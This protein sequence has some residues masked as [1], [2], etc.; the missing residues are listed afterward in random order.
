[1]IAEPKTIRIF[2]C[3]PRAKGNSDTIVHHFVQG[4]LSVGGLA[5]ITYLRD[6]NILPCSGC[7]SCA[8]SPDNSCILSHKDDAEILFK[9]IEQA[10]LVV[11]AS[12]I[13]FYALPANFKAFIDRAQRF[14]LRNEYKLNMTN[15]NLPIIYKPAIIALI[16]AR[17]SGLKLFE[18][19]LLTLKYFLKAFNIYISDTCQLLGFDKKHD[20]ANDTVTCGK[21]F[22]LGI[23]SQIMLAQNSFKKD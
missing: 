2:A 19:S 10:S 7:H 15:D 9:Q 3:S 11:F 17:Q 6:Y 4:I 16:A 13:Y 22:D 8:K 14:W 1:M 20:L 5:E 21:L 18:G 12:P 23:K